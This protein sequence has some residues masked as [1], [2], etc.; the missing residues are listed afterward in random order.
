M[1]QNF[2]RNL[3]SIRGVSALMICAYHVG[4]ATHLHA[5]PFY[6][7]LWIFVDLFFALSGFV[8]ALAYIDRLQNFA[9]CL[10]FMKRR[11]FRI[12]PLHF[13]TTV[14]ALAL[15]GARYLVLPADTIATYH[16]DSSW[17]PLVLSIFTMTHNFGWTNNIIL[18]IPSWS[19]STEF[20]AYIVFAATCLIVRDRKYRVALLVIA[21][22]VSLAVLSGASYSLQAPIDLRVFRCLYGFGLGILAFQLVEYFPA[23][24][25][26][27]M[28]S[29]LQLIL[30][31]IILSSI[32]LLS[33]I[34]PLLY[35]VPIL[36]AVLIG[37]M[38]KD[39]L[40]IFF[41]FWNGR[42]PTFLG[43]ISYSTYLNHGVIMT[44]FGAATTR[45]MP[46][47]SSKSPDS[48]TLWMGDGLSV[49]F[50]ATTLGISFVTYKFI[51][52]PWR[53]RGRRPGHNMPKET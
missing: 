46:S 39:N 19:I 40:S 7:N 16:I 52:I 49:I 8:I 9:N 41:V 12:Y 37:V 53:E 48:L 23:K 27:F 6:S 45:L 31:L 15:M 47:L 11:L 33:E 51:E 21:A 30:W 43:T 38:A 17:I 26:P 24:T 2:Y 50:L 1:R 44:I 10:S 35:I 25:K 13:V 22:A 42:V 20:F 5:L 32:S 3:E 34:S 14:A 36:F 28:S 29:M 18:N 4:W